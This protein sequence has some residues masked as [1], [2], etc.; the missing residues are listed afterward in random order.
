MG[1]AYMP[2]EKMAVIID[3]KSKTFDI[4]ATE[5]PGALIIQ[6]GD[7]FEIPENYCVRKNG[8]I[9]LL[10]KKRKEPQFPKF[11]KKRR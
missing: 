3:D 8:I 11:P 2:D 4:V 1:I 5:T 7:I 9:I 10:P 6:P